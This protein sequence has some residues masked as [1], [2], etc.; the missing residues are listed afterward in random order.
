MSIAL[1]VV[2]GTSAALYPFTMTISFDTMVTPTQNGKEQRSAR[3]LGLVKFSIPYGALTMAQKNTVRDAFDDALGAASTDITLAFGG[4]TY[5][6]LSLDSD[7]F[8]AIENVT[9]QY[10][11]PLVLSQ[12]IGQSLSPGTAGTDYPTLANSA[13]GQLPFTQRKRWQTVAQKMAA[14]PKW[15]RSEFGGSLAG[16][17]TDGLMGWS[18]DNR[19]LTDADLATLTAH[20]IAN[21]GKLR[22]FTFM[23]EDSSAYTKTHYAM[24]DMVVT[25]SG[26]NDSSVKVEL[27][28][29]A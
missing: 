13:M 23:D 9:T 20:F 28:A 10:D 14:G 6:N 5:T 26:P 22:A 29:I 7:V 18:F 11:G 25:Y 1:P 24:D 8:S 16:Y 12:V 21:A 4:T 3:R 15:T 17:P 27:E 2:R 19:H